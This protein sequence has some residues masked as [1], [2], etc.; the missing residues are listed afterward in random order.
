[1]HAESWTAVS[2]RIAAQWSYGEPASEY[3]AVE[4]LMK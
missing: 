3:G 2:A 1:L 4:S